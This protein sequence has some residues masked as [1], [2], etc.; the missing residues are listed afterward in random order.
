MPDN[1]RIIS[2]I[3]G[4]GGKQLERPS[5]RPFLVK[6]K[7]FSRDHRLIGERFLSLLSPEH[8]TWRRAELLL[9]TDVGL[10][11]TEAMWMNLDYTYKVVI[12]SLVTF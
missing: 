7:R 11:F 12:C 5:G 8:L 9:V 4:T 3:A 2:F 1:L 10:N 6:W